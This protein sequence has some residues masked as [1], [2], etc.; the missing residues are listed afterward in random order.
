MAVLV[1]LLA[2][3][4]VGVRSETEARK[5]HIGQLMLKVLHAAT[6]FL[7]I[8]GYPPIRRGSEV[9]IMEQIRG[10]EESLASGEL[11]S[12]LPMPLSPGSPLTVK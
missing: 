8:I 1:A 6:D 3:D 5:K 9:T 2:R 12:Y 7:A 11:P 10:L 4:Q